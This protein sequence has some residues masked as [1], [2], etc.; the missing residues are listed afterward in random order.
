M[1]SVASLPFMGVV[2]VVSA[3]F[4]GCLGGDD[5]DVTPGAPEDIVYSVKRGW[6]QPLSPAVYD[7]LPGKKVLVPSFDGTEISMGIFRPKITGCDWESS[8]LP[9]HCA[10][11]IVLTSSPYWG[12]NVGVPGVRPPL[13]EWLVPRG[14][15][16]V[17]MALRG[18]GES[19]GCM[20]FGSLKEQRDVDETLTWLREQP[21]STGMI[22][23][24]GRS[25]VG[26]TPWYGAAFGNP[27]LK[28]I[29]PLMGITDWA[30][31]MF[32]N[33]TAETR[34]AV[35]HTWFTLN[36]GLGLNDGGEIDHRAEHW[37]SQIDCME[38]VKGLIHGPLTKA[39]ADASD[40][41]WAERAMKDRILENYQGSVW[42]IQ[43]MHDWNVNPHQQVP[44]IN[45]LQ[46]KGLE[47]KAWL[48]VW[49]HNYPDRRD[50]HPNPRWDWADTVVRWFDRHLKGLDVDTGPVIETQD[51]LMVWRSEESFPP[52]DVSWHVFE[53]DAAGGITPRGDGTTGEYVLV[54]SPN[55][56]PCTSLTLVNWAVGIATAH[57]PSPVSMP[58]ASC[59]VGTVHAHGPGIGTTAA[60]TSAP[61]GSPLRMAGLP[62]YH[63][64]V[65]PTT[66]VGGS[67]FAE[68]YDV[69]PDGRTQRIGWGAIDVRN[70]AGG[71]THD[72]PLIPGV[73][74]T[75]LMEFEPMDAII[76]EGHRMRLVVH[77]NGVETIDPSLT[78]DPLVLHLGGARSLLKL[79]VI[80][81]SDVIASYTPPRIMELD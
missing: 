44:M 67:L 24:M 20:E 81:R 28:T 70:H 39:L 66:P 64:T 38:T 6:S 32:K 43:G 1:R 11:P 52:R 42:I 5:G 19:G 55:A 57:V 21:W 78:A 79:P 45:A 7:V 47:V 49:E 74:V 46:D 56:A 2:L 40:P 34:G 60:F 30:E 65:V 18:T 9:E 48:G 53:T 29:V 27:Y 54:G 35:L 23:M 41:Y 8:E 50:E 4:A 61:L 77:K 22:G 69:W 62:R 15:A 51:N 71:Y 59:P 14:Y 75:A 3:V 80:E 26:T 63:V 37:N 73:P 16:V 33:G 31:L 13:V 12:P 10:L 58:S 36:Y 17:Q 68:L 25:Y 76:A 72:E